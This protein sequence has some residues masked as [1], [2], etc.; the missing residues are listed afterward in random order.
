MR[1]GVICEGPTDEPAI[2]NFLRASLND[3]GITPVFVAIQP[4]NDRTKPTI[5][6]WHAVLN[7]LLNN[8]PES[9]IKNYLSGGLFDDVLSEK[10]CDVLVFQMDSDILSE[11]GFQN[12]T[13]KTLGYD[14][15]DSSDPIQR[16]NEIRS[17]IGIAGRFKTLSDDESTRHIPAPAVESTETWCVAAVRTLSDDPERL[18]GTYLC[19]EFMTALHRSEAR[20]I[21]PFTQIDKTPGRRSRFCKKHAAG[22]FRLVETQCRHYRELVKSLTRRATS[23]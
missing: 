14:V 12:W 8:S 1:I 7:W 23:T 19:Q 9:R 11:C 10:R 20:V 4:E 13:R 17:I 3:R 2:T 6:N 21:Q 22:G 18:K 15:T 5:G 16:G